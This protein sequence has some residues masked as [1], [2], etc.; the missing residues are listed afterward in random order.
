MTMTGTLINPAEDAYNGDGWL[1]DVEKLNAPHDWY[2]RTPNGLRRRVSV[3]SYTPAWAT[4]SA[5]RI[6][7]ITVVMQEVSD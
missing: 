4:Q 3:E 5:N 6:M 2:F 7:D 1:A